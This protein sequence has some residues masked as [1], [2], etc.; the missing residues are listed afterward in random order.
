MWLIAGLGNPGNK[1]LLTRH[2]IGFMV[3]DAY[4]ASVGRP[5]AK[6]EHKATT[7]HLSIESQ[8]CVFAL[9]QTYMNKSGESLSPLIEYYGIPLERVLVMHDEVDLPFGSFKVQFDRGHGG[10]NGIR[11]IHR[12]L[13][14][15]AYYR[16]KIGVG[17]PANPKIDVASYV[18]QRF[19]PEEEMVLPQLLNKVGDAIESL[20][21]EGYQ[22]TAT[23]FNGSLIDS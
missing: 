1:Y 21:F 2:N 16:F 4:M 13:G 17:R 5:A 11:D 3:V 18:L 22:K 12:A 23:Q 9:P 14:S 20:I 7:Y 10:H 6:S 19:S 15:S 8:K